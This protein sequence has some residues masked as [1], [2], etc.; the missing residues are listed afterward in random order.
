M[1]LILLLYHRSH[2]HSSIL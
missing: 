1:L 2:W